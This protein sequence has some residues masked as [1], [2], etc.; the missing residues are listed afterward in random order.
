MNKVTNFFKLLFH[1]ENTAIGR[2]LL[3]KHCFSNNFESYD[4]IVLWL[5]SWTRGKFVEP[6]TNYWS[7]YKGCCNIRKGL[8]SSVNRKVLMRTKNMDYHEVLIV[9]EK[10]KRL[11]MIVKDLTWLSKKNHFFKRLHYQ[12]ELFWFKRLFQIKKEKCYEGT[13]ETNQQNPLE[14]LLFEIRQIWIFS[15]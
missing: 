9:F 14:K 5:F 15:I 2:S 7:F 4:H 11:I 6:N 13:E 12:L 10:R 3:L 8:F 1:V